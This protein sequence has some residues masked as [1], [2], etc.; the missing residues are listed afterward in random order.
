M[1]R[2]LHDSL[3]LVQAYQRARWAEVAVRDL[4]SKETL[5]HRY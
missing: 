1:E 5:S 3:S 4:V 2:A